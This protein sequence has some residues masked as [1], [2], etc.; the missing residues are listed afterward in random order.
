VQV[1]GK[2]GG[3]QGDNKYDSE[4]PWE[5]EDEGGGVKGRDAHPNGWSVLRVFTEVLCAEEGSQ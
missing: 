5:K 3:L 2:H 4:R 1:N